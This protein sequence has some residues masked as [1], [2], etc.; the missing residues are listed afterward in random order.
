[1]GALRKAGESRKGSPRFAD[2]IV[3][4][5]KSLSIAAALHPEF[6]EALDMAQATATDEIRHWLA[7]HSATLVGPKGAQEVVTVE[8]LQTVAMV[9]HSSRAG[10]PAS[11]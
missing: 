10:D 4:A 6:C 9:H 11:R 3:N 7:R 2:L 1:M 8:S 5:P